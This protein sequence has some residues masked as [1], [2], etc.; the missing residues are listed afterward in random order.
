MVEIMQINMLENDDRFIFVGRRNLLE[1]IAEL[2]ENMD[3]DEFMTNFKK[4]DTTRKI[5]ESHY[6]GSSN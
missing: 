5:N 1:K 2:T 3:A 4:Y 6:D